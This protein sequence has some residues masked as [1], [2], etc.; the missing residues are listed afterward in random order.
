MLAEA[1]PRMKFLHYPRPGG[2]L[3]PHVDLHRVDST[4]RQT[5]YTFLLYISDC[6]EGGETALLEC[7]DGDPQLAHSGGLAPGVR[8]RV[9]VVK[10]KRGRIFAFPHICPHEALAT[11]EVPKVL[12]RGDVL[13]RA[14]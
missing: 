3:P 2:E 7:L 1:M 9:A 11:E 6:S 10:P 14:L 12:L 5:T 8:E 4:G 13:P